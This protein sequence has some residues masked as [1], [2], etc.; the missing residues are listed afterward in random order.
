M[1]VWNK[2]HV[3]GDIVVELQKQSKVIS[4]TDFYLKGMNLIFILRAKRATKG[5]QQKNEMIRFVL[6][7]LLWHVGID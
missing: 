4:R 7:K 3:T 1:F 6:G 2:I 5:F